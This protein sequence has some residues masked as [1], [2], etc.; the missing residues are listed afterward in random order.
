M[1]SKITREYIDGVLGGVGGLIISL[2]TSPDFRQNLEAEIASISL[3][4]MTHIWP[5]A[6]DHINEALDL[7]EMPREN[8]KSCPGGNLSEL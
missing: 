7:K 5:L 3:R 2:T 8:C 1:I 6:Y 4:D